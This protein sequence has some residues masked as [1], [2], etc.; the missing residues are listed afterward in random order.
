MVACRDLW[1]SQTVWCASFLLEV[2][3]LVAMSIGRSL[4]IPSDLAS[5]TWISANGHDN[6]GGV[7]KCNR[8][9][10]VGPVLVL[11]SVSQVYR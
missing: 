6:R 4:L 3:V 11:N 9:I 8:C 7:S 1:M 5:Q 2:E 10:T